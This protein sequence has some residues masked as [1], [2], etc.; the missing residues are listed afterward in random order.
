MKRQGKRDQEKEAFW[1]KAITRFGASGISP[2]KF[3]E[4]EGLK[5]AN[6]RYWRE[7]IL[8]RDAENASKN[9]VVKV[10]PEQSFVPIATP[11][12]LASTPEKLVAELIFSGG[13]LLF[14]H[15]IDQE[16]LRL[17]VRTMRE[18]VI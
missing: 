5:E 1:R 9:R 6:F 3:C 17:L 11:N 18:N 12:R 14:F 16:T 4:R 7:T 15:G 8:K 10:T 2:P 13:S